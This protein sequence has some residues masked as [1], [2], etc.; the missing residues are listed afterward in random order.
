MGRGAIGD[1]KADADMGIAQANSE[2]GFYDI[3]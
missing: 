1:R 3:V 2:G